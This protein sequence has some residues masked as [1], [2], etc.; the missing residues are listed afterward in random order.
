MKAPHDISEHEELKNIAPTLFSIKKE[1]SFKV[2]ANYFDELPTLVQE[3]CTEKEELRLPDFIKRIMLVLN[4]KYAIPV[5]MLVILVYFG[6]KNTSIDSTILT[7][8]DIS[9]YIASENIYEMDETLLIE[10][11]LEEEQSLSMNEQDEEMVDYLMDSDI[12]MS[13]IIK[14][15]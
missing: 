15:L 1:N 4:H 9:E 11:L 14:E 6:I 7:A 10:I 12:D 3:K 2:P 8:N 5:A 13:T